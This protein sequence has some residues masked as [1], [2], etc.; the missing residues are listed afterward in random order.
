MREYR[1]VSKPPRPRGTIVVD[2]FD[3]MSIVRD[4]T[5]YEPDGD[6]HDTGLVD[7]A[8]TRLMRRDQTGPIGFLTARLD[9]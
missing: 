6:W 4:L 3:E 5:V 1:P 9:D 2:Q 8:G 7:S